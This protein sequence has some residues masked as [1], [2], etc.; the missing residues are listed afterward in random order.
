MSPHQLKL[1]IKRI[2]EM[3]LRMMEQKRLASQQENVRKRQQEDF[4]NK[5]LRYT[6]SPQPSF[7]NRS[8][9]N[10][11]NADYCPPKKTPPK[12]HISMQPLLSSLHTLLFFNLYLR[13]LKH[14][15][16]KKHHQNQLTQEKLMQKKQAEAN[17]AAQEHTRRLGL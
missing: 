16:D 14:L 12:K 7:Q 8:L 3:W 11:N 5:M 1:N 15:R 6:R 10:K 2:Q 13:S 9:N 4:D 17:I